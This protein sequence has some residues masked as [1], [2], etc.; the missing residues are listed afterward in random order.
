[1]ADHNANPP[2]DQ[3]IELRVTRPFRLERV[4]Q[5][6]VALFRRDCHRKRNQVNSLPG[7]LVDAAQRG[8]MV[9]R[10]SSFRPFS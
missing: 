9:D 8:L 4:E 10:P 5:I 2:K 6:R 3:R 7:R 1:M